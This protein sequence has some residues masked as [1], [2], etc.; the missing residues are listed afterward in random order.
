M[1]WWSLR[2]Q[3]SRPVRRWRLRPDRKGTGGC[4]T[5]CAH[6]VLA[7]HAR[8][9]EDL[10]V[11]GGVRMLGALED[12]QIAHLLTAQRTA[13]NHALDCLF[14]DTLGEATV[15]NLVRGHF[16]QATDVTRVLVIDLVGALLAGEPNL[17]GVDDDDIVAAIDVR[18]EAGLV[19]AAQDVCDDRR[20]TTD[21]QAFGIDDVPFL[22][23]FV[24]LGR[25]GGL[26]QRL[27]GLFDLICASETRTRR[28]QGQRD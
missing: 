18:G 5:L 12:A 7:V 26:H 27:H 10:R 24:R 14:K 28:P 25:L 9:V 4:R 8:D 19:L 16:L 21:H 20:C 3:A 22:F 17:V 15:E 2:A 1:P 6:L 11:L 13:R 23:H